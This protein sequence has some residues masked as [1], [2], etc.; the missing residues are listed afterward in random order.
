MDPRH[1]EYVEYYRA[2]LA[3][4]EGNALY[5]HSVAAE[6]ALFEAISSAASLDEFRERQ[7]QEQ[8][9]LKCAIA[10]VKDVEAAEAK[11]YQEL[12]EPVRA[13]PS[14][15]ILKRLESAPPQ[16]VEDLNTL[17]TETH[18]RWN[19][20]ISADELLRDDFWG[21]WKVLEDIE[22]DERAEV[23]QRWQQERQKDVA[24][25]LAGG[26]KHYREVTLPN[27]HNFIPDWQPDYQALREIRHRRRFP[28]GNDVLE[29]KIA[30]H[31]RYWGI[32]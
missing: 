8:L 18:T 4:Y 27:A 11:S 20:Q 22:C 29:E 13:Q 5:A 26:A 15:E 28:I 6:R 25:E 19:L 31:K 17:V 7:E 21:D 32:D 2:R 12:N 30:A 9:A 3:K 1:A 23:P 10:R 16:S 14:L 24:D